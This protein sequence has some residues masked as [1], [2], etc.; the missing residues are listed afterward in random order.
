M[1]KSAPFQFKQFSIAH[2]KCAMKVNTDGILLGAIADISNVQRI[3]DMGTGSGLVA[4][5][6]AQR[7][8]D[9][10]QI[11]ALELE[12]NAYQQAVENVKNSAWSARINVV[13]GDVMNAVFSEKFDLIV[14]NPPYFSQSLATRNPQRDLARTVVQSHLDWL[15]QAK[16]WLNE[17]GKITFILPVDAGEKLIQETAI[18][19][20]SRWLISPKVNSLPKRMIVTFSPTFAPCQEEHLTIYQQDQQYSE[21]FKHFTREFY[22]N[23]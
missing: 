11:T 16:E 18:H 12:E 23:M 22:L 17:T 21:A 20:I 7:T 15:N 4:L 8:E 14:S 1:K 10:C 2:D 9:R 3:L 19:C 13:H 5:M 6:L